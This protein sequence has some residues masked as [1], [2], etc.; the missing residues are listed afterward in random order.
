LQLAGYEQKEH[1]KLFKF[2]TNLNKMEAESTEQHTAVVHTVDEG[3]DYFI[4][5]VDSVSDSL[6]DDLFLL[7]STMD[8]TTPPSRKRAPTPLNTPQCFKR[9]VTAA[10]SEPPEKSSTFPAVSMFESSLQKSASSTVVSRLLSK[11]AESDADL[12]STHEE[13]KDAEKEIEEKL[14]N[15]LKAAKEAL[16]AAEKCAEVAAEHVEV[17]EKRAKVAENCA[18]VAEKRAKE[19]EERA[20]VAETELEIQQEIANKLRRGSAELRHAARHL[21]P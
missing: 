7:A 14:K 5:M 1:S 19:A 9:I 2:L 11:D 12:A 6:Q 16:K 10:C 20:E 3:L 8:L 4:Q 18:K 21:S 13:I 17:A 15:D